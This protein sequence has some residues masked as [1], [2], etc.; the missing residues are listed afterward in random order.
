MA[1]RR[2]IADPP[3]SLSKRAKDQWAKYLAEFEIND[4]H[5]LFVLA[6][7]MEAYDVLL[8]ATDNVKKNGSTFTN[9]YGEIKGNPAVLHARDARTAMLAALKALHLDVTPPGKPGRPASPR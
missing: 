9:R 3:A 7:A 1:T 6:A 4:A 2:T 5:G 8:N